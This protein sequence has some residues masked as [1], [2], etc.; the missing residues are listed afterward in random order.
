M[1]EKN[2]T[3]RVNFISFVFLQVENY[4]NRTK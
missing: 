1:Q 4:A 2:C 3:E